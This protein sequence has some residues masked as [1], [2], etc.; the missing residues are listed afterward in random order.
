MAQPIIAI[1]DLEHT[2]PNGAR[3]LRGITLRIE[4]G[5][6]IGLIGQNGSG[7]TT[8]AKHL[9]GLLRPTCGTLRFKGEDTRSWRASALASKVGYV[10]QNPD[11]QIFLHT[12]YDEVAFGPRMLKRSPAQVDEAVRSALQF[13][14]LADAAQVHPHSLSR[15]QRQRLAIA[16]VL[17]M[18]TEVII[19]DEPTGGQDRLQTRNLMRLLE[20]LNR[21][22]H[23]IILITHDLEL[24]AAH[25]RR[26]L[27]M[28]EGTCILDG[29][30]VQVFRETE[31]LQKARLLAPDIF[32]L[33]Q[34][35]AWADPA[36]SVDD[37][38]SRY[39]T[40]TQPRRVQSG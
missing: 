35:L 23:T 9:N 25:C 12:V 17:A 29:P 36:L 26:V 37:F 38:C 2:Y 30:P 13:M 19:L 40:A 33:S 15:G 21:Q 7:K 3:A 11:H 18:R 22:G 20:D 6:F 16:S 28:F 32:R 1:D 14:D 39:G 4:P 24:A 27:V 31:A 8:L 5:E 34:A 10:F